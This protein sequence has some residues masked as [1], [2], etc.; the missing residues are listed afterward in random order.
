V[1][2]LNTYISVIALNSEGLLKLLLMPMYLVIM[3]FSSNFNKP[4]HHYNMYVKQE[5]H[6]QYPK[7]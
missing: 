6:P 2:E 5:L 4:I 1:F 3:W 7:R